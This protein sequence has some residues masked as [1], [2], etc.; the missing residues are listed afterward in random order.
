MLWLLCSF[1]FLKQYSKIRR[2]VCLSNILIIFFFRSLMTWIYLLLNCGFYQRVDMEAT[3]GNYIFLYMHTLFAMEQHV[4]LLWHLW[5]YKWSCPFLLWIAS[6]GFFIFL[7]VEMLYLS[8]FSHTHKVREMLSLK[9]TLLYNHLF[10]CSTRS[11]Q[12]IRLCGML[13]LHALLWKG[14]IYFHWMW[15]NFLLSV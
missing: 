8:S 5:I 4:C 2:M 1:L 14:T 9:N 7:K 11:R 12:N 6:S 3:M 13:D 10:T 15:L